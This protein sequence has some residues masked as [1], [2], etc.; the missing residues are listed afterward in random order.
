MGCL[1]FEHCTLYILPCLF[2][3]LICDDRDVLAHV[4][5]KSLDYYF[6]GLTRGRVSVVSRILSN[7]NMYMVV[8]FVL[9]YFLDLCSILWFGRNSGCVKNQ[10]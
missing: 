10:Q 4:F 9:F 5:C 6:N 7:P 2:L 1:D 3:F 8:F